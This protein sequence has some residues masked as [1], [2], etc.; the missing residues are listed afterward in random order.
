MIERISWFFERVWETVFASFHSWASFQEALERI[1]LVFVNFTNGLAWPYLLSS[2]VLAWL[3]YLVALR[4]GGTTA[5]SFREYAF[6]AHIYRH[7]STLLDLRFM[8][9]DLVLNFLMWIPVFSGVGLLTAKILSAVVIQRMGWE[10]PGSMTPAT[11]AVATMG[12]LLLSDLINYWAHVWLHRNPVLWSFHQVHHSAEVLTPAA[13]FRVHP[14][15]NLITVVLQA[16][17]VG[18]SALLFQNVLGRDR[19]FMMIFGV[20]IF[21]FVYGLLGTHLRH[22]HIWMS[23]GPWLNRLV[24]SPAHHQLHHSIDP[25]HWNKNFGVKFTLWDALFGTLYAPGK[26][27]VLRVGIPGGES[28][29]F[30]TV[31]KLYGTPFVSAVRGVTRLLERRV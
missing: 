16:P 28:Q 6:P 24:M 14:V 30:A 22:S 18:L 10:P 4:Q 19:Q 27:E 2:L 11:I 7:P 26:P 9:V 23:Y 17:V 25:R 20:S 13:A 15:E 3:L 12:F 21:G 5:T 31:S 29:E 1:P 8:A